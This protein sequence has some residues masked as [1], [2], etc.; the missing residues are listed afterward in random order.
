ML[1]IHATII[2][3]DAT[4]RII[5]DGAILVKKNTIAAIDKTVSLL[6]RYP[7]EKQYDLAGCIVIPGL[8]STHI[9]TIQTLLRGTADNRNKEAWLSE[10]IRLLQ[11]GMT[12]AD[13]RVSASLTIAEMLKSGT[14][15][16]LECLFFPSLGFDG[17]CE[18]VQDSGIRACLAHT[19]L[20]G[21]KPVGE[22]D[23]GHEMLSDVLMSW[24][25]WNGAANDRIRQSAVS[26][27]SGIRTTIH[28]AESR[29]DAKYLSSQG[30]T[31]ASYAQAVGL[32]SPSTVLAHT[33]Y[34]DKTRDI[35][36]IASAGAH[37]SHCPTSNSKLA[38]GISPLPDLL[39]A[40]VNVSLGTD[41]AACNN[42]CDMFLEMRLA[43]IVH[44]RPE[45]PAPIRAET[46]L[47]MATING[48]KA[49]GL[50]DITG[51]LQ[52][53]KR[54]DFVAINTQKAP[55]QPCIDPVSN[56]V[57]ATTGRDVHV[58]VVDG[59]LVV[60]RGELLSMDEGTILKAAKHA[61]YKLLQRTGLQEDSGP[62][63]PVY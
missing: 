1:Y 44:N 48:A 61:I 53:G 31:A 37:I 52:V 41:G 12:Q 19:S 43:A 51:S 8:I 7:H 18:T 30:H 46:V 33:V 10:R 20:Q 38:S 23:L 56:V 62:L 15:C 27:S 11:R 36:L 29:Q 47:E 63:W 32:L 28:L 60:E 25:K 17:L 40:G 55:L 13:A 3:V 57:Y 2:T 39:S 22:T 16:F 5:E 45:D 26:H 34:V 24:K 42:T 59:Q 6:G 50:D 58:V 35:P 49:L 4:R 9:H 14:T 21:L 54:A